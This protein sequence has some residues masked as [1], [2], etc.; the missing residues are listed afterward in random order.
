MTSRNSLLMLLYLRTIKIA[1]SAIFG[2][3]SNIDF[4]LVKIFFSKSRFVLNKLF[5]WVV[6]IHVTILKFL[7][8]YFFFSNK[9]CQ[10]HPV[11]LTNET[12]DNPNLRVLK[13]MRHFIYVWNLIFIFVIPIVII[14]F[15]SWKITGQAFQC[16]LIVWP[17]SI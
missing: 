15:K 4:A 6:Y 1:A 13:K 14:V 7:L 17:S 8:I 3:Y 9:M 2:F 12:R 10:S 5:D 16:F 11:Y